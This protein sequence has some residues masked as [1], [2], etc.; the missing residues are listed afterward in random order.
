M[1]PATGSIALSRK[2]NGSSFWKHHSQSLR[3]ITPATG[4]IGLTCGDQHLQLLEPRPTV[5]AAGTKTNNLSFWNRCHGC[6]G[7]WSQP[8]EF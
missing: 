4:V 2:P 8:E 1:A 6:Y 3:P 7:Q 5:P